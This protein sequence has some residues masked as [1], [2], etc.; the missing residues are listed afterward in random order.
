MGQDTSLT[1]RKTLPEAYPVD[2]EAKVRAR[3]IAIRAILAHES[4]CVRRPCLLIVL[5]GRRERKFRNFY[6]VE[7]AVLTG[8]RY[9]AD[10][11]FVVILWCIDARADR[12]GGHLV[13]VERT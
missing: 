3:P 11:I 5:R 10:Q 7:D 6:S 13:G 9:C 4:A 12:I 1:G 2:R 8:R